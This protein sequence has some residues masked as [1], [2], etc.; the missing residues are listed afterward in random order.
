MCAVKKKLGKN[1]VNERHSTRI[2]LD[3]VKDREL[4]KKIKIVGQVEC[5]QDLSTHYPTC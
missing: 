5:L 2:S 1:A 3:K 4:V